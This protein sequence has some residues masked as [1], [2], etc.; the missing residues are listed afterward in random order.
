MRYSKSLPEWIRDIR[1]G[2]RV[3]NCKY[4]HWLVAGIE[5]IVRARVHWWLYW[6][7]SFLPTHWDVAVCT[8]LERVALK[9]GIDE[10][11]D[12][13]V[14]L[15]NDEQYSLISCCHPD[16]HEPFDGSPCVWRDYV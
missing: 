9:L 10:V 8:F 12:V 1:P 15:I 16:D 6:L 4:E 14:R 11:I 3:C 2:D 13:E 7:L 5:P